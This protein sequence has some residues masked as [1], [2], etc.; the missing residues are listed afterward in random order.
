LPWDRPSRHES[1]GP[2]GLPSWWSRP[3][4]LDPSQPGGSGQAGDAA[5]VPGGGLEGLQNWL[6]AVFALMRRHPLE[7]AAIL[8]IGVG[9]LVYPFP[10]WLFGALTVLVSRLWDARDKLAALT[11]PV[12][13]A[14]FGAVLMAGLTSRSGTL[15]GYAHAV[16]IDG[17]DLI[18]TGALLSAVYLAWRMRQGRRPHREPP[19]HRAPDA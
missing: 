16:R 10:L 3:D 1:S 17:W 4:S 14:M 5:V 9:V 18:R 12:A 8:L 19:W 6:A 13:V 2:L 7:V 11:V 15:S